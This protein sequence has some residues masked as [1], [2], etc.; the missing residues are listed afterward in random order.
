MKAILTYHSIDDTGSAISIE[1][2]AFRGHVEWLAG[3]GLPV[4]RPAELLELPPGTAAVALTFD[5]AFANFATLAWPLLRHHGLPATLYVAAGWVGRT[6]GWGGGATG[7]PEL[8]LL[9]WDELARMADEGLELGAHSMT[10]PDLRRVDADRL[11]DEIGGSAERIAERTGQRPT[12]FAYPYGAHDQRTVQAVRSIYDSACTTELREVSEGEDRH[13]LP[14]LDAYY[15]RRSD[16]L[17]RWGTP[18]FRRYIALRRQLRRARSIMT[19]GT[20]N[21]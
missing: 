14:R 6:N 20:G 10:H 5:D 13:R 8:S 7:I 19:K 12:S 17:R 15:L 11:K 18:S 21:E 4:V 16:D 9:H 2:A 1:P 3:S